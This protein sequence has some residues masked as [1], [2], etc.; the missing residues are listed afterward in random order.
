MT[1]GQNLK[2]ISNKIY[3]KNYIENGVSISINLVGDIKGY[4]HL[5]FTEDSAKHI[6][7]ALMMGMPINELDE[8]SISALSELG[9][10]IL[11]GTAT[12]LSELGLYT[13]ITTPSVI[14]GE[15]KFENSILLESDEI[16]LTI[17]IS[18]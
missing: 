15:I 1:T 5:N 16:Q 11:G 4:I 6:A 18:I 9:N 7:S 10:M 12:N 13:D 8:M 2:L 17:D 14:L 3:T